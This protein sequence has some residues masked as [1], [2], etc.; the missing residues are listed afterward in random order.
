MGHE[1]PVLNGVILDVDGVLW[2]AGAPSDGG[3]VFLDRLRQRK[4]P[5]C[6]LTNDCSVSKVE[7]Q[8]VLKRAGLVVSDA[9][10]VTA[11][12]VTRDWLKGAGVR[13]IMYLGTPNALPDVAEGLRVSARRPVDAVVVGDLFT[14]YDRRSLDE[15]VRAVSDGASLVAMQRNRLWF[16]GRDSY[17]DNGCWGAGLEYTTGR[18]AT[19]TGKPSRSAYL[20]AVARLGL[21][22]Q[23][24]QRIAFVSDDMASD[25]RGAKDFGLTTVYFGS[26]QTF[27]PW[28]DHAVCD[29]DALTSL[30]IGDGHA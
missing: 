9:Q 5:F 11:A 6:L 12:E 26:A 20:T 23:S 18:Q 4:V 16:D 7:R 15:A 13:T 8:E 1:Y 30:L 25:L 2:I 24:Y 3:T 27:L 28:V 22:A 21:L 10:L 29:L 17:V 14:D 19:V